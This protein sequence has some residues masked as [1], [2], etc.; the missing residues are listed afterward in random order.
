VIVARLLDAVPSGSYL[1]P[2]Q[3]GSELVTTQA[4]HG[5]KNIERRMLCES[6]TFRSREQVARFF[7]GTD[8]VAP[9]LVRVEEWRPDSGPGEPRSSFL[10]GAVGRQR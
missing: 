8:L 5:M 10:W 6:Y 4:R 2:S 3:V 7:E 1:A 9:G